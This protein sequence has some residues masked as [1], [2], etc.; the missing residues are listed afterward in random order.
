MLKAWSPEQS[1]WETV[2]IL[3]VTEG[4]ALKEAVEPSLPLSLFC[5]PATRRSIYA[6]LHTPATGPKLTWP[7]TMDGNP[8]NCDPK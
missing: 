6:L 8:Q 4:V 7:L 3:Q 5:T 2:G 1:C